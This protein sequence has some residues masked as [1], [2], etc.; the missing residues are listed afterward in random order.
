[1]K[2]A[3]LILTIC[4]CLF[5]CGKQEIKEETTPP[6]VEKEEVKPATVEVLPKA[7][8]TDE[9]TDTDPSENKEES[10]PQGMSID[11]DAS[12]EVEPDSDY[13]IN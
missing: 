8:E 5:A 3:L 7:D 11:E 9:D 4:M 6:A 13:I 10:S 12:Y 1:M 2:K